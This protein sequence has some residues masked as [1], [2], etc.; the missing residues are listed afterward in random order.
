MS[1]QPNTAD[2][3]AQTHAQQLSKASELGLSLALPQVCVT[4]GAADGNCMSYHVEPLRQSQRRLFF[5]KSEQLWN[6]LDRWW[7]KQ[8]RN[9]DSPSTLIPNLVCATVNGEEVSCVQYEVQ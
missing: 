8:T 5:T 9:A 7:L 2:A 1:L 6:D 4:G 3:R